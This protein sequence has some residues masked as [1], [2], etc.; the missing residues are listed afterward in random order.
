[1]SIPEKAFGRD[2]WSILVYAE[3]RAVDH[4]G[5]LDIRHLRRNDGGEYPTRVAQ[6]YDGEVPTGHNDFD[7]L[8]DLDDAGYLDFRRASLLVALTDKGWQKAGELRRER[9]ERALE[10]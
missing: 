5:A 9:A 8:D 10:P 6:G 7:C 3:T 4:G 1:M 2:H